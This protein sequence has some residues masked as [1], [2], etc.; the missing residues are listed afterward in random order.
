MLHEYIVVLACRV[1]SFAGTTK[2]SI[3]II[4]LERLVISTHDGIVNVV[5]II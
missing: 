2:V 5:N 4:S 3:I 1:R